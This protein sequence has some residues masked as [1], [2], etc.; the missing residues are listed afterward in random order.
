MF[1][2][3][4]T[5]RPW[6]MVEVFMLGTLVA[7]AKLS[8]IAAV[9]PGIALWSFGALMFVLAAAAASFEPRD[10]WAQVNAAGPQWRRLEPSVA[11]TETA[12]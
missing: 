7:L 10:F 11:V 12:R 2:L 6:G 9:L 8:H 5:V 3:V 4:Q 1:R